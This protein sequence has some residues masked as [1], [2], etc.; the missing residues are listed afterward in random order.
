[1]NDSDQVLSDIVRILAEDAAEVDRSASFPVRGL[2]A[3]REAGYL[4][5][6]VPQAYGGMGGNL[7][8]LQRIAGALSGACLSTGLVWAMH[9]QQVDVLVRHASEE[10]KRSVLPGV[11]TGEIYLASVTTGQATH[12]DLAARTGTLRFDEDLVQIQRSAPIV[13]GGL[14]ADAF[15]VTMGDS[16]GVSL[17]YATRSSLDVTQIGGWDAL[18]MRGTESV[19]LKLEGKVRGRDVVGDRGGFPHIASDSMVPSGHIAWS[20]CWLGSSRAALRMLVRHLT[21][22]E[23]G[24]RSSESTLAQER[25]A[26]VRVDLELVSAYLDR[27]VEE[28]ENV[29]AAGDRM[30]TPA[31]QIHLNTLKIVA[32]E[33]TFS[34]VDRMLQIAGLGVGYGTSSSIPL[35]RIFRDLRSAALNFANDRLLTINGKLSL[36]DRK[37]ALI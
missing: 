12:G 5:L 24:L 29:R 27:V 35:E 9:C 8:D 36:V 6:L 1:M 7:Q 34:A 32:S 17:V 31:R 20:S 2:A 11:A 19:P 3:L 15:L 28:V 13:T 37:V 14:H 25:L 33:L 30:D 4:G 10:L 21:R 23:G 26:R 18:G 16:E 22:S